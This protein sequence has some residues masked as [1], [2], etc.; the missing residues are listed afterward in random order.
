VDKKTKSRVR[1]VAV[2]IVFLAIA[3]SIV[4]YRNKEGKL[5]NF[6]FKP[7]QQEY[8]DLKFINKA[9][10][11]F[12]A[13]DVRHAQAE[14][15]SIIA[16]QSVKQIRKQNES[17]FGAYLFSVPQ[18]NLPQVLDRLG[19]F[20]V[21]SSQ[22]EQIDTSLVNIDYSSET[23]RMAS[24]EKEQADLNALRFP[25]DT[26]NRRK[27]ALHSLIHQSRLNLDKLKDANNVLLYITLS[28]L[29]KDSNALFTIKIMSISFFSWLG[30]YLVGIVIAYFATKLLMYFLAAIGIKGLSPGG[31]GGSYQYGGYGSYSGK[32][33]GRYASS[34]GKRKVKRVYKDKHTSPTPQD[35]DNKTS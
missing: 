29:Q 3:T 17:S 34:G 27:E 13:A 12:A 5:Q 8:R 30:I 24:Y 26:Q 7:S 18:K 19:S 16:E 23:A 1:G 28:P 2:F 14:I 31:V 32:Y 6:N 20:G 9:Q 25:T 15:A 22:T 10:V 35:I 4:E 33:S 11:S 21:I